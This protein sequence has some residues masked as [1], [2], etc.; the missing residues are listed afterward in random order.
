M[1]PIVL[2]SGDE[3]TKEQIDEIFSGG[4]VGIDLGTTYS[5]VSAVNDAGRVEVLTNFEGA[6]TTP[7]IVLFDEDGGTI[8]GDQARQI[9]Q[10]Q[11]RNVVECVKR[12]MGNSDM[13]YDILG[14]TYSPEGISAII[15]GKLIRDA[16]ERLGRPVKSAV[17][18]TP[19]WFND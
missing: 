6:L 16:S 5:A 14:T 3:V 11:A 8:V 4:A 15:L 17:I 2:S 19:A 18:T 13:K 12:A 10:G 7:S 1:E 9:G